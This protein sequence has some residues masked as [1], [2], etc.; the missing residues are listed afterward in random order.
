M[1]KLDKKI[2]AFSLRQRNYQGL[3]RYRTLVTA[4]LLR[5]RKT[6]VFSNSHHLFKCYTMPHPTSP[7]PTLSPASTTGPLFSVSA[8][9]SASGALP[10]TGSL[11]A[12]RGP[13]LG[14]LLSALLAACGG[15]GS[16]DK[17]GSGIPQTFS[18]TCADGSTR[19][20]STSQADAQSRC[21]PVD[22]SNSGAGGFASVLKTAPADPGYVDAQKV[23]YDIF[24]KARGDCGFGYMTR[25]AKLDQA[26]TAHARYNVL[27]MT[28]GHY[29][30]K[31]KPGFTGVDPWARMTAAGYAN[32]PYGSSEVATDFQLY[33]PKDKVLAA[34]KAAIQLLSAP[35]HQAGVLGMVGQSDIGVGVQSTAP[36]AQADVLSQSYVAVNVVADL[37]TPIGMGQQSLAS[38]EIRTYPCEGT[39]GTAYQLVG[40]DP[41]PVPGRN[42]YTNPIGQPIFVMVARGHVLTI[43]SV[44]LTGPDGSSLAVLPT[45]NSSND[46]T[47]RFLEPHYAIIMPDKAMLPLTT[48]RVV[49][50]GKDNSTPFTRQFSFT[51]GS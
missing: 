41:N 6:L 39:T 7:T 9:S 50:N 48:Y 4:R 26:A 45:L 2:P 13:G 40:E 11:R 44:T 46:T 51:T 32:N 23:V 12:L 42:L 22:S 47:Q 15:G 1:N 27:N 18:A 38:G 14:L 30:I 24:N 17:T 28:L 35:Y 49:I 16:S 20:S 5:S 29:Q 3:I 31:G 37:G 33:Y 10:R 34:T 36:D 25:N 19:T 43:V 21:A 8:L